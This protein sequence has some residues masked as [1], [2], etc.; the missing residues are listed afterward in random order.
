MRLRAARRPGRS[1]KGRA[2]ALLREGANALLAP[3]EAAAA[4]RTRAKDGIADPI[5]I[6]GA[7]RSGTTLLYQLIA[8]AFDVGY[9]TNRHCRWFRAPV[10]IE[11][12]RPTPF[13]EPAAPFE[14]VHGTTRGLH[15]PSECGS[16]WYRFLPRRPHSLGPESIDP[17]SVTAMRTAVEALAASIGKPLVFKNLILSLRIPVL[18]NAFPNAVFV[19]VHRNTA[20]TA[21]SILHARQ[22]IFGRLDR[23]FSARPANCSPAAGSGDPFVDVTDQVT[24]TYAEIER[25][26]RS[27]ESPRFIDL[28]YERL[29]SDPQAEL[30]RLERELR[31]RSITIVRRSRFACPDRFPPRSGF[32]SMPADW[33]HRLHDVLSRR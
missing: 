31:A 24:G 5:F 4:V 15:S 6:V 10:F 28:H 18:V 8:A 22:T 7:P 2:A 17:P 9:L 12:R 13:A 20:D 23:W 14:S 11:R 19:V 32:S 33:Q 27:Q 21:A 16:Y 30:D 26:R 29:C 25:A 3:F 1:I